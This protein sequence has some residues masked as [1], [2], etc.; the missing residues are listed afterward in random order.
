MIGLLMLAAAAQAQAVVAITANTPCKYEVNGEAVTA[1]NLQAALIK[2]RH[3]VAR[4]LIRYPSDTIWQCM[5]AAMTFA[6]RAGFKNMDF[7]PP[8]SKRNSP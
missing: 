7:N 1:G 3:K 2:Q 4:V 5:G 8:L 6:S